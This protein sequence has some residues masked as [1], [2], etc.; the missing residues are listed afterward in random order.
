MQIEYRSSVYNLGPHAITTA[1]ENFCKKPAPQLLKGVKC[2]EKDVT[3]FNS[4]LIGPYN[5]IKF[6]KYFIDITDK[7]FEESMRSALAFHLFNKL[8]AL[9]K[10]TLDSKSLYVRAAKRFCPIT[11]STCKNSL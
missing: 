9:K 5:Y 3:I 6:E 4:S 1:I 11:L 2:A 10:L 8:S 7:Q